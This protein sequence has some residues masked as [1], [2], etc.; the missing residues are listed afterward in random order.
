MDRL[1]AVPRSLG[2]PALTRFLCASAALSSL[3]ATLL[4]GAFQAVAAALLVV[5]L[6]SAAIHAARGARAARGTR[7]LLFGGIATAALCIALAEVGW[8]LGETTGARQAFPNV[9]D[10]LLLAAQAS[11]LVAVTSALGRHRHVIR[12]ETAV[13]GLLLIAAAATLIVHLDYRPAAETTLSPLAFAVTMLWQLTTATS[14]VVTAILLA[15]RGE[16]LGGRSAT[17]LSLGTV[18]LAFGSAWYVRGALIAGSAHSTPSDTLFVLAMLCYVSLV[19]SRC[20]V[21]EAALSAEL[22]RVASDAAMVRAIAIVVA[23]LIAAGS[24][25][26]LGWREPATAAL[27]NVVAIFGLLLAVRTG[28]ALWTGRRTT[29]ALEH[30]VEAEREISV[31][32]EHCV[33]ARTRELAEAQRVLQRMWTLAQQIAIDLNPDRVL[34]RYIE[35]VVDVV[36]GDGGAVALIADDANLYVAS[37]SGAASSLAG[38]KIAIAGS[39]MGDVVRGGAPWTVEDAAGCAERAGLGDVTALL[40][41]GARGIAVLPLERRGERIGAVAILSRKARR[42]R[43]EELAHVEAMTDLV[44]VA[45]SNADLVEGLRRAE[46]RFRTLFRVAPDA[47]LTVLESGRIREANDAIRDIT[48]LQPIQVV[49]HTLD[50]F[51]VPNDRARL[52]YEIAQAIAGEPSRTEVTFSHEDG[53]RV[54]AL[55]AR[56]LPEADPPAVLF[57]G[58]DMTKERAMRERLAETERL[59]AVGELVAGV[60]HEVNNPLSTISAYAQLLLREK[61][62]TPEQLESVEIIRSETVRASQVLRDLLTFA[63]RSDREQ[64]ALDLNEVVERSIR[65]RSYEMSSKGITWELELGTSLPTVTGDTRQLQQVV[66]N[67]VTNAIQ[68]MSADGAD[69]A[70]AGVEGGRLHLETR[71]Q[72]GQVILEVSDTGPGVAAN[73]RARIFEPFFTTKKEGTGLGLSVSYGIVTAHGGTIALVP[74]ARGATFRVALP[75]APDEAIH[76]AEQGAS[77]FRERSLLR[78]RRVLFV[79]DEPSL[80]SG[81]TSFGRLRR[82][83]VVTAEDGA[84]ALA[85]TRVGEFDFIVC[86]LRMPGM[87]GR[88]FY[89][90]LQ[91]E[92]PELASRTIFITGDVVSPASQ[93]FLSKTG[94]PVLAKPFEFERLEEAMITLL[95]GRRA[96]VTA[97]LAS[98]H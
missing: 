93:A 67:L 20:R 68:A 14:L 61:S 87:D 79:D 51:V 80:C 7:R 39:A 45:L 73:A 83:D 74:S 72:G 95:D 29:Q 62:L 25:A 27:G 56:A 41:Q 31:T 81:V 52:R 85:A 82:F 66:L 47:V 64:Q 97:C 15:W 43:P 28:Y 55:A 50:E 34:Q 71:L 60:A 48:G 49:G 90:A 17:G 36:R 76:E 30:T 19:E 38:S 69:G 78:G 4:G 63:R 3:A 40:A 53:P 16:L 54:V 89:E 57:V 96:E 91:P 23:I 46:W 98:D 18:F 42:F 70:P 8:W 2:L 94:Q 86:D 26:A 13:D 37:G 92:R 9:A 24:A 6:I 12:F 5:A 59:A 10:L 11:I 44:S 1:L 33:D 84:A 65:L 21:G 22:P 77:A 75:A 58:R 88:A 32:L 35:A